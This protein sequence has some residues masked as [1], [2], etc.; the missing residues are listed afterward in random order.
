M[1]ALHEST[2]EEFRQRIA[3][4]SDPKLIETGKAAA[5]MS[6]PKI[7]REIRPVFAMQVRECRA[8]WRRRHPKS[9]S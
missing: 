2:V 6:D 3:K 4:I 8:E 1:I 5:Y 7:Q 9:A